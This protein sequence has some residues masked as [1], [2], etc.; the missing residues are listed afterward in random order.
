MSIEVNLENI[1]NTLY[2]LRLSIFFFF[3]GNVIVLENTFL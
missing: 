3:L 1:T 2:N